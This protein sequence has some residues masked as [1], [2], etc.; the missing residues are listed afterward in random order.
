ML[1]GKITA[2]STIFLELSDSIKLVL[3]Q[4]RPATGTK[5]SASIG[6]KWALRILQ[7]KRL[8]S[9]FV[10]DGRHSWTNYPLAFLH[11]S[12]SSS[13]TSLET[14]TD[15][16]KSARMSLCQQHDDDVTGNG[17]AAASVDSAQ[18][19]CDSFATLCLSV[20]NACLLQGPGGS[21]YLANHLAACAQANPKNKNKKSPAWGV[22]VS[23][24]PQY[25]AGFPKAL[26]GSHVSERQRWCQAWDVYSETGPERKRDHSHENN[27]KASLLSMTKKT[28]TGREA[29]DRKGD[30]R[31]RTVNDILSAP[32]QTLLGRVSCNHSRRWLIPLWR[33]T[34]HKSILA[35][36][37][38]S[39]EK[40][41]PAGRM[42]HL[43]FCSAPFWSHVF[44]NLPRT[45]DMQQTN[46]A[47]RLRLKSHTRSLYP[48]LWGAGS[49]G[50]LN[51]GKNP[52]VD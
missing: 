12:S 36:D 23:L 35:A 24:T 17:E 2:S 29:E 48:T 18:R 44:F 47:C 22:F 43:A 1:N 34:I 33:R 39:W 31:P 13:L 20:C 6:D 16:L 15:A 37:S 52:V 49:S 8:F 25:G 3:R 28:S 21:F 5:P 41:F 14:T 45:E 19:Y 30:L 40:T 7:I 51:P 9:C 38:S 46:G 4:S 42:S 26:H 50:R 11:H 32:P 27:S 10:D